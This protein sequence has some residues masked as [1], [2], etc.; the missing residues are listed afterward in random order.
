MFFN[1]LFL[2][3]M[4]L[5]VSLIIDFFRSF[6]PKIEIAQR[7]FYNYAKL[8]I[9]QGMTGSNWSVLEAPGLLQNTLA[10]NNK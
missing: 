5:S 7:V 10:L 1:E 2:E 4:S 3:E 6:I 8:A 9:E